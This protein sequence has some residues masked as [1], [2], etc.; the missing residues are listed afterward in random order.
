[1]KK[2]FIIFC[3]FVF[4]FSNI[5]SRDLEIVF[6]SNKN[7]EYDIYAVE[8]SG[9]NG[10]LVV[11]NS[12]DDISP[13]WSPF[14]KEISYISNTGGTG[15]NIWVCRF[16]GG[17]NRQ[18]PT[19]GLTID[20]FS[21]TTWSGDR[22]YI[23][24]TADSIGS[25][26][27]WRISPDGTSLG[28]VIWVNGTDFYDIYLKNSIIVCSSCPSGL[29][30]QREIFTMN[31]NGTNLQQLTSSSTGNYS[32]SPSFAGYDDSIVYLRRNTVLSINERWAMASD[33]SGKKNLGGPSFTHIHPTWPWNNMIVSGTYFVYDYGIYY[34]D[35]TG[36]P[37]L[38]L[39]DW[40]GSNEK[41]GDFG[42][43]TIPPLPPIAITPINDTLLSDGSILF[44]WN[45]SVDTVGIKQYFIQLSLF[46]DFSSLLL[47]DS[48]EVE[49]L[50][51][52]SSLPDPGY[53]Y[54]RLMAEDSATNKS[55]WSGNW[56]FRKDSTPPLSPD[57]IFINNQLTNSPWSNNSI[58]NIRYSF[59]ID[60]SGILRALYKLG[61]PP[62]SD[63]DTTGTTQLNPFDIDWSTN[64]IQSIYLWLQDS[65]G[66][67][68]YNN[69]I[70]GYIRYDDILP[71]NPDTFWENNNVINNIWQNQIN[72]P[73][74][75]WTGATDGLSGIAGFRVYF[76]YNSNGTS[77]LFI[78]DSSYSITADTGRQF[79]RV[80]AEDSAGNQ[81]Q[82]WLTGF[83]FCFDNVLPE[84]SFAISPDTANLDSFLVS[85]SN[86]ID[87]GGSGTVERWDI[88]YRENAGPWILWQDDITNNFAYFS[89]VTNGTTYYF[90]AAVYDSANNRESFINVP[91]CSTFIDSSFG[92][93]FPPSPPINLTANNNS[94]SPWSSDGNYEISW[95]NPPDP[96]GISEGRYKL[97][98]RP[99]H[100]F[101]TTGVVSS[102]PP[103]SVSMTYQP[104]ETLWLFLVD[105][106]GNTSSDS[107]S[108]VLLR[109]DPTAPL[110][111]ESIYVSGNPFISPWQNISDF[112]IYY[113]PPYDI[114]GILR[115]LYKIDNNPPANNY[116]TTGVSNINPF[117][118]NWN[119]EG[120]KNIYL[121]LQDSSGNIDYNNSITGILRRDISSPYGIDTCWETNGIE[122]NIW[123]NTNS[124]AD[125]IWSGFI[126]SLSGVYGFNVYFG[127]DSNSVS[128]NFI[129][130]SFYNTSADTARQFLRVNVVDSAGNTN[131][132]HTI[133]RF[134]Y[135][136]ISPESTITYSPATSAAYFFPVWWDNSF[137]LGGS[138]LSGRYQLLYCMDGGIPYVWVDS[139]TDSIIFTGAHGHLYSFTALAYDSASN[140]ENFIDWQ[141]ST[142]ILPITNDSVPPGPP[143]DLLANGSNPSPW[144]DSSIFELT[145]IN[146]PDISGIANGLYKVGSRPTFN[147]DTT[148]SI[149]GIS[150]DTITAI[151]FGID[152]VF[153]WLVDGSGNLSFDSIAMVIIKYDS[154]SPPAP[155]SLYINGYLNISPW[156][157]DSVFEIYYIESDSITDIFDLSNNYLSN[158][159][160]S[161]RW[162][163][164]IYNSSSSFNEK[165]DTSSIIRAYYKLGSV[166]ISNYD[167][168]GTSENNPFNI[169]YSFEGST[170]FYL[171]LE[172]SAGNINYLNNALGYIRMDIT[173]PQGVDSCWETNGV[174]DNIWQNFNY[175]ANFI[176]S[177]FSDNL[178]GVS[179]FNVYFGYDN[180]STSG[181]Y[182][183]D[184]FYNIIADTNRQYLRLSVV[185][186]AGNSNLF[187][188]N[189][190]FCY[191]TFSPQGAYIQ[192]PET[193]YSL[194]ISLNWDRGNDIGGSGVSNYDIWLRNETTNWGLY[195]SNLQDSFASYIVPL[196]GYW[197]YF[198]AVA[199]D[200]AG[201]LQLRDGSRQCSTFVSNSSTFGMTIIHQGIEFS[202]EN[203]A[204][205]ISAQV[206]DSVGTNPI[207]N[208]LYRNSNENNWITQSMSNTQGNTF[209]AVIPFSEVNLNG[210]EY[211]IEAHDSPGIGFWPENRPF[212]STRIT[213]DQIAKNGFHTGRTV[214][215]Y[216]MISIP[217]EIT[218]G[219]SWSDILS[220]D[221]GNYD[222]KKWRLFSYNGNSY[223]ERS[224]NF[225]SASSCWLIVGEGSPT[226]DAG[227]GASNLSWPYYYYILTS[228]WNQISNPY[229]FTLS[230]NS[231]YSLVSV[232]GPWGYNGSYYLADSL[233]PWEGYWVY[234]PSSQEET[235]YFRTHIANCFSNDNYLKIINFVVNNGD[236]YDSS[237]NIC[238]SENSKSRYDIYDHLA[239]P[240]AVGGIGIRIDNNSWEENP[241][242]YLYDTRPFEDS[243]IEKFN[244]NI[245]SKEPFKSL[246]MNWEI[247]KN[248]K[249]YFYYLVDRDR[250]IIIDLKE[251]QE[252]SIEAGIN[253]ID[254]NVEFI[255]TKNIYGFLQG[256]FSLRKFGAYPMPI[257]S[258]AVHIFCEIGDIAEI[259]MDVFDI[260]GRKIR[261]VSPEMFN[262][263]GISIEGGYAIYGYRWDLTDER[264]QKVMPGNYFYRL[265]LNSPITGETLNAS[266]KMVV[267]K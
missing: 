46:P 229:Y 260:T 210:I 16:D 36:N 204:I 135:D 228:G 102:S 47:D 126:D 249:E 64:G 187:S 156:S 244:L 108:F 117:I 78:S 160:L 8:V 114:S 131:N 53:F 100:I 166:P 26:G 148:G 169:N 214:N 222:I 94:P 253:G 236:V 193:V 154:Y 29:L 213:T 15:Y 28:K 234:N 263:E 56:T 212:W 155:E 92:D 152:S 30:N 239:P 192:I 52:F 147:Y 123:Q 69:N 232:D 4:I 163:Q 215:D 59:P 61:S 165:H 224:Y 248:Y 197:Y 158:N 190:N 111:P 167:T 17:N 32:F 201:N 211:M 243:E 145:W 188:T 116:D 87:K 118:V 220:D 1:M 132:Y 137:D 146:P 226:I 82:F 37:L 184:S 48:V 225:L 159:D 198:E 101:D 99:I 77:Q 23:Y 98:A 149:R 6:S 221:L 218:G 93:S 31:Q 22:Q 67:I 83:V 261:S 65:A 68:D 200:S 151:N 162:D 237:C 264:G 122:N 258:D 175:N 242:Y 88:Q 252:Y 170:S 164:N 74:F 185:D 250:G 39:L 240:M 50:I 19:F 194:N 246:T 233:I 202:E 112:D 58:F 262:F 75:L 241:G 54:W 254:K 124:I 191:D 95:Q 113:I 76:G 138:G 84:S 51:L 106:S 2:A 27:I 103:F 70:V 34:S 255:I 80:V 3:S 157:S 207:V 5:F 141:T 73:D 245:F 205:N 13:S 267:I 161:D 256:V 238:F 60:S 235:L 203:E 259:R 206:Y 180:S 91:E 18:I 227:P 71:I 35:K 110:A 216:R 134:C 41:P 231:I 251:I 153:V 62:I 49:S 24:F 171:W 43:D 140:L 86:G 143:I 136:N 195:Y 173:P 129:Q 115:A 38:Q 21:N 40:S 119:E 20:S 25:I 176:W 257:V 196:R 44:K 89:G 217:I 139:I 150:P 121:W 97:G 133:F 265:V 127:Y 109:Y 10:R 183:P 223:I 79:L 172:D 142:Y 178:S 105:G 247:L 177:G 199:R 9:G 168:T 125:F 96:S 104:V 14:G 55:V 230:W 209:F 208:L 189:F 144:S 66:N 90:E 181:I 63:F 182:S 11:S 120:L 12:G 174:L 107:V 219:N 128:G 186:S 45:P 7:G 179:G 42:G 85:W 33:G 57:S 266:G 81:A 72:N 130:D